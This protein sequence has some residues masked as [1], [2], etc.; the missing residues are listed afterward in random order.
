LFL[1]IKIKIE[2]SFSNQKL[3][4]RVQAWL[5]YHIWTVKTHSKDFQIH[6]FLHFSHNLSYISPFFLMSNEIILFQ[7][8][9][10]PLKYLLFSLMKMKFIQCGPCF[11]NGPKIL[12][13][14]FFETFYIII[15]HLV[16][17]TFIHFIH[18]AH[19]VFVVKILVQ[20]KLFKH[21]LW[22]FELLFFLMKQSPRFFSKTW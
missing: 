8:L 1:K 14:W 7:F 6:L 9:Y 11:I 13:T 15:K 20:K 12:E 19:K 3:N 10:R 2:R 17:V 18:I 16:L 5:G 21:F 4:T 22:V